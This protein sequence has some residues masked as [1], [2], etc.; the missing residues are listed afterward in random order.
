MPDVGLVDVGLERRVGAGG[1]AADELARESRRRVQQHDE[2]RP[3]QLELAVLDL[4]EPREQP[5]AL[6][7]LE[8]R[9]LVGEVG[10][11]VA[12]ADDEIV[13]GERGDEARPG[14]TAIARVEERGQLGVDLTETAELA[15]QV[16]DDRPAEGFPS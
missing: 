4:D 3:R 14:M 10:R 12:V 2:I 5:L 7:A 16:P 8:L 15:V 9:A 13:L 6:L 1:L 11:D